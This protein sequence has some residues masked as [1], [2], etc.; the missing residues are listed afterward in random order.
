MAGA[1][2]FMDEDMRMLAD[3]TLERLRAMT[4]VEFAAQHAFDF[5]DEDD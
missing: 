5:T 2:P 1:L 3:R 4:D